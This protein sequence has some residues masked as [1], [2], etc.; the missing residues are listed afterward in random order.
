MDRKERDAEIYAALERNGWRRG[1]AARELDWRTDALRQ[2]IKRRR[3]RGW[4]IPDSPLYRACPEGG[5]IEPDPTPDEI[6]ER[7]L[8]VQATWSEPERRK[9]A[10]TNGPQR[11]VF[12][13]HHYD[14][15]R[16]RPAAL[17]IRETDEGT[18]HTQ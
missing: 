10:G 4:D 13:E 7:C 8:A 1:A 15:M 9:R 17:S 5:A 6:R 18:R 12:R 16:A 2:W 11:V 14:A 3:R